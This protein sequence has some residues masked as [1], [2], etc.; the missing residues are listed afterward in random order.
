MSLPLVDALRQCKLHAQRMESA[1]GRI[2]FP[3]HATQL[4]QGNDDLITLLDQFIFRYTK[5]QD[6]LGEHVLR[7]FCVQI[8]LE[9][10]ENRPLIDVLLLLERHA[11]LNAHD[12]HIHRA[13]R[14]TLTHE[15]PEQA[16][17]QAEVLNRA[18]ALS[19]QLVGLLNRLVLEEAEA[20][21]KKV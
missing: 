18:H 13:M 7:S 6:A 8:L 10:M 3:L 12:W 20:E 17:W 5:L 15:Y 1:I 16:T 2:P 21:G 19:Q 11:Y 9:P 14:N 4:M